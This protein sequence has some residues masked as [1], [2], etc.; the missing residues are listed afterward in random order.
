[1]AEHRHAGGVARV[2]T[3]ERT[4]VDV[5]DAP[6]RCGGWEEVWRSLEMI[7]YFD[8]DAVFSYTQLLGSAL[9]AARVGLYLEQHRELLMVETQH[10][11]AL[12]EL[13][14]AQPRYLD[15]RRE[16]GKLVKDWNLVVPERVLTRAW[17]EVR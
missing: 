2:T 5:L 14:P 8:L 9:T 1:V 4:L 3:L 11:A 13:A 12:R 15:S 7:E 16:P 10:L 17:A 6:D